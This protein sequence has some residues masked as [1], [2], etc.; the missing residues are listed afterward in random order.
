VN[1]A[2]PVQHMPNV[3]PDNASSS[4]TFLANHAHTLIVIGTNADLRVRQIAERVGIT[5]RAAQRIISDLVD[6]GYLNKSG[7]GRE[8]RYQ[9]LRDA[10]LRHPLES[11]HTVGELIK[12]LAEPAEVVVP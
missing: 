11:A 10:P 1:Q 7:V 12:L 3:I 5:E 6:S 2:E 8:N 9:V 4:W